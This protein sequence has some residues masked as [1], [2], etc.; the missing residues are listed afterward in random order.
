MVNPATV[1]S[2]LT[3]RECIF[4]KIEQEKTEA[5]EGSYSAWS[6]LPPFPPVQ[7]IRAVLLSLA[8]FWHKPNRA[9]SS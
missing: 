3:N 8:D 7:R 9:D 2:A 6:L 5:T 1:K 4:K